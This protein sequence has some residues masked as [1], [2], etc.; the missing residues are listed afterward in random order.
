MRRFPSFIIASLTFSLATFACSSKRFKP[1]IPCANKDF[2]SYHSAVNL[3]NWG[4]EN[5][6]K[7]KKAKDNEDDI[8]TFCLKA[9]QQ[10]GAAYCKSPYDPFYQEAFLESVALCQMEARAMGLNP[11]ELLN[12]DKPQEEAP[13]NEAQEVRELESVSNQNAILATNI[14]TD[15]EIYGFMDGSSDG[16]SDAASDSHGD[17]HGDA[18]SDASSDATSDK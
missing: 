18:A 10:R 6:I 7:A 17:S 12:K 13:A 4:D 9:L 5:H 14:V 11:D 1:I 15:M 8:N 16:H 3:Y 2:Q